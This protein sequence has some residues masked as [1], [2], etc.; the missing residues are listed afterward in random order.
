M[1]WICIFVLLLLIT[2]QLCNVRKRMMRLE[3]ATEKPKREI[4]QE[5]QKDSVPMFRLDSSG[6]QLQYWKK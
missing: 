2:C 5:R 3:K 6:L 1:R 4:V